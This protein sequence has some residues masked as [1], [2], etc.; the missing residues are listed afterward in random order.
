[1][2]AAGIIF[3][4]L[5][6]NT[7][8]RLTA[9]RTVAAIPFGCRY[10]LVDF[11]LSNMV[12][13]GIS[14]ISLI[15]NYNYRSLNEHIG[16]GKDWDLARRAGGIRFISPYQTARTPNS[17]MYLHHLEALKSMQEFIFEI[18][19]DTV[20]LCDTDNICNI[21]L[22]SVIDEH[23]SRGAD[24][25]MVTAPCKPE[26]SSKA[27]VMMVRAGADDRITGIVKS[28][29][30][31]DAYP[32][33]FI[34]LYV[35]RTAY[36]TNILNASFSE[37]LQSLSE[38]VIIP[39][40]G[41]RKFYVHRFDGFVPKV[42]SFT[43]YYRH[44][45]ALTRDPVLREQLF[46]VKSRPIYTKVH[47]SAPVLY[48]TGATVKN[49]M[50]A[51]GC[52]IEGTVENSILFRGVKVGRGAVVRDSILFGGTDIGDG[53]TIQCVVADKHVSVSAHSTL[54]GAPTLP[55]FISKGRRV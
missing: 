4:N 52:V 16:S 55:F 43:D 31:V 18:S 46:G 17:V 49:S 53:S 50:I 47:N 39:H 22:A 23:E 38:D 3:S 8:S 19:E 34:N 1:M 25:T 32:D 41:D 33:R 44:S 30:S 35:V 7:L 54:S 9:D 36:L 20:V 51:D 37:N 45:I 15:A 24:I 48:K 6:D 13:A 2:S 10:R 26:F 21:D 11:A 5:N 42:S 28:N 12:N 29:R 27:P 14:N 40:I